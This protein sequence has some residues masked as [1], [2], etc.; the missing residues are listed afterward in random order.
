ML[1]KLTS[2]SLSFLTGQRR[3]VLSLKNIIFAQIEFKS[4]YSVPQ[5]FNKLLESKSKGKIGEILGFLIYNWDLMTRILNF[6]HLL[7]YLAEKGLVCWSCW[8]QKPKEKLLKVS[9]VFVFGRVRTRYTRIFKRK[10]FFK[11]KLNLYHFKQ[12]LELFS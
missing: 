3:S 6:L 2:I 7:E 5:E 10:N 4:P 9:Q 11:V 8:I 12:N 1:F